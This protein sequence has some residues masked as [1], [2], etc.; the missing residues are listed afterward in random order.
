MNNTKIDDLKLRII[1]LMSKTPSQKFSVDK[2]KKMLLQ[3]DIKTNY[4]TVYRKVDSL[5]N[6]DIFSK[7]MYGMASEIKINLESDNTLSLLSLI[8]NKKTDVFFNNLKGNIKIGLQEIKGDIKDII[9]IKFVVIFGSFAK[10]KQRSDSD[11]DILVLFEASK[12]I[13]NK[14]Y[15]DNIK[16]SIKS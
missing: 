5:I 8:E 14:D 9:E 2:I 7:S 15:E 4:A 10:G 6:Q 12:L 13:K 3:D 16:S 1:E 11:L